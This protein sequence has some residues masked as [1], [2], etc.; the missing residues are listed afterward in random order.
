MSATG[1]RKKNLIVWYGKSQNFWCNTEAVHHL[2]AEKK[3]QGHE[4][5]ENGADSWNRF[6]HTKCTQF[7]VLK[8]HAIKTQKTMQHIKIKTRNW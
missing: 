8:I 5:E 4:D 3:L 7:F 2:G 1:K 6:W